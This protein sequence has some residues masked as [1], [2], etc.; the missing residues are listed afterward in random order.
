MRIAPFQPRG[1]DVSVVLDLMIHDIDLISALVRSPVA[2]VEAV[3]TPVLSRPEDI[4]NTRLRFE[5]GCVANITA[6]R[7]AFKSERRMRIFQPDSLLSVDLLKRRYATVRK[8]DPAARSTG[9]DDFLLDEREFT[10]HDALR[11]ELQV[12]RHRRGDRD[13]ARGQRRGRPRRA[14]DRQPH[15]R[16][17]AA[18]RRAGRAR[19]GAAEAARRSATPA[20][21][22]DP[23]LRVLDLGG[24]PGPLVDLEANYARLK[25]RVDARLAAALAHGR[26]ILGPEV[27]ELEAELA[28][29]AGVAHAVGVA[30]GTRRARD[31]PARRRDRPGR[32]GIRPCLHLRRDRRAPWCSPA[33]RRSSA[34]STLD[35][36]SRPGRP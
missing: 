27:A 4:V 1:N 6:S 30:S 25:P 33:P 2:D 15:H 23:P 17:P 12:L 9:A 18:A 19:I 29:R 10:E 8:K 16:E 35:V 24:G 7:V 22:A 31:R 21:A 5:N 34:T 11:A 13:A 32:R 14:G 28:R 36:P 26:F 20:A 3:G